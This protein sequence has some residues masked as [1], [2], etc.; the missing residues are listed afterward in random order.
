MDLS[1]LE[2]AAA[3]SPPDVLAAPSVGYFTDGN[4]LT[5]TPATVPGA[6]FF[7]EIQQE[8][9]N[10]I[11]SA[12]LTPSSSDLTQLW[13]AIQAAAWSTGDVK[14][15]FKSFAD[16]GWVMMNDGTIGDGSSGATT[17]ANADTN[18]LFVLLWNNVSNTY[19]AVSGGRG[20]NAA[21]D[22]AAHKTIAL[23]K[24]LGRALAAAGS[25]SGLT[26]RTLG[27]TVGEETHLLT[28]NELP[29]SAV[30]NGTSP[31]GPALDFSG[32]DLYGLYGGG[33]AHNNMQP[34]TFVNFM[35]KL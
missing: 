27:Q 1:K 24:I 26:A 16:A 19:A 15:T 34:S 4:P 21:A 17:R 25:G 18:A 10:A 14:S 33:N 31:P 22:F 6:R 35:I 3:G 9:T 7:H 23:P 12:G 8:L 28:T 32:P 30:I 20:A 5:A 11:S 2:A 13:K 29:N